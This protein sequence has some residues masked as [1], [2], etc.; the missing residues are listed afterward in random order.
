[1]RYKQKGVKRKMA[2]KKT[3]D[4]DEVFTDFEEDS[5]SVKFSR[6]PARNF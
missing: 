5:V 1:M 4:G 6:M 3:D 2:Y